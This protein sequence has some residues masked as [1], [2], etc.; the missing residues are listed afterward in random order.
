MQV[1]NRAEKL[2]EDFSTRSKRVNSDS[3]LKDSSTLFN[4]FMAFVYLNDNNYVLLDLKVNI[5]FMIGL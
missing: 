5:N 2:I 1:D 3:K 4:M